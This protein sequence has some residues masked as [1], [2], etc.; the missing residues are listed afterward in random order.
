MVYGQRYEFWVNSA[1]SNFELLNDL[2]FGMHVWV[3]LKMTYFDK[4]I[5][6]DM[7]LKLMESKSYLQ[8]SWW[9]QVNIDT[10]VFNFE[11]LYRPLLIES[12]K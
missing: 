2:E 1:H 12:L 11:E 10:F 5:S 8:D 7:Q 4:K 6:Q 9:P 3:I